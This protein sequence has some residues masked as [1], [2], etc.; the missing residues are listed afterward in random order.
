VPGGDLVLDFSLEAA[1]L[2]I[3][4]G[5]VVVEREGREAVTVPVKEVGA[6]GLAHPRVTVT[7]SVLSRLAGAGAAVVVADE[8]RL[9]CGLMLPVAG[10][11]WQVPRMRAQVGAKLP[12]NKRL[13]QSIVRAKIRAQASVLEVR[14]GDDAGLR[15]LTGRVRSGDPENVEAT[16]AQRYWPLLFDDPKFR[17]RREL[18]DQNRLLNYGYAIVRAAVGRAVCAAGLH[19]S[20]G[21]HHHGRGDA[22]CLASDLMEPYRA[23]VDDRVA[24]AVGWYGG[25]VELDGRVRGMLAELL[26]ERVEH[27]GEMRTVVD[28]VQR[29]ATSVAGVY[30]GEGREVYYPSGLT[31]A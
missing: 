16:A 13:W 18:G 27:A 22:F 3:D 31:D 5:R 14:R 7:Q 12:T 10:H 8:E 29:T 6:L 2:R 17:R 11:T 23:L 28:H 9:P 1:R 30:L 15:A 26:G 20:I 25:N 24:E 19:P 4:T 21:I